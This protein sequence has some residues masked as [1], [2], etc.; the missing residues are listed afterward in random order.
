[1][2]NQFTTSVIPQ[3]TKEEVVSLV[4]KDLE[5][6]A[7]EYNTEKGFW[8][9]FHGLSET[10]DGTTVRPLWTVAFVTI[11]RLVP[12]R[13]KIVEVTEDSLFGC[14]DDETK[15]LLYIIHSTGYM[16]PASAE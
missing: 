1:M 9:V 14:V 15:E 7:F 11:A 12:F 6:R 5:A 16:E 4:R 2:D 3:L 10:R 8:P 13:G